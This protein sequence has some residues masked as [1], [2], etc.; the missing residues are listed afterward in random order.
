MT[1]QTATVGA[2]SA[3]MNDWESIDWKLIHDKVKRLQMRI[4]KAV[5]ENRWG[6]VKVLQRILTR[7]MAAKLWA[8]RRVVTN[9]GR[10]TPGVDGVIWTTPA[11][12]IQGAR[13]LQR[14]G[15][16]PQ[17]LRRIHIP[18]KDGKRMRPLSIPTKKDR[19]MQALHLLAL[20]PIA[21][22]QAD[23][24]SYG[25][26]PERSIADAHGQ[27][28]IALAKSYAPVWIFEGDIESCFDR[29]SH[30][31]LLAN[32][33]MD[34]VILRMWLKA[35]YLKDRGFY[36]TEQGTPQG[37][38]ISP[39][40]ANM[41][42]DGLERVARG[43]VPNRS[44]T[45]GRPKVHV[46]RYADDFVITARSREMLEAKLIPA[47]EH[48]LAERDLRLSAEKSQITHIEAGF[49]F[50]GANVR[51]YNGKL[52]MRPT[53]DGVLR[54]VKGCREL[55]RKHWASRT[56]V[57]I[58]RLNAKLRGWANQ[59]RHLVSYKAF[60]YIDW[61]IFE[62]LKRWMRRRHPTKNMRWR[63]QRYFRHREGH[64]G[65][66][67]SASY[68]DARGQT[69][70]VDL[71]KLSRL[72]LRKH[73]KIQSKAHPFDPAYREYFRQR[74]LSQRRGRRGRRALAYA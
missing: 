63:K 56:D 35:G 50:L 67:F 7:S 12:K 42:L 3:W 66:I 15:Y 23:G 47:V 74:W 58:R 30:E 71:V 59:F 52:L 55:M 26:R 51:K 53:K 57:L 64:R 28:F 38:I 68:R 24:H 1:E 39:A 10:N 9:R 70:R 25:Y 34:K 29:I 32:I 21:E 60:G 31:W 65:W 8:T 43:A 20:N 49:D 2:P 36:Y 73:A 6:K 45:S 17:P 37:G 22:M 46:I 5:R 48:F 18:K 41:T 40:L 61:R 11:Q 27:C 44:R 16:R 54:L 69:R 19:A 62:G 4:A 14:R 13:S 72:G 33:P